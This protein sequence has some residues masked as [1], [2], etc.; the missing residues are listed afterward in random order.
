MA[1]FAT[2]RAAGLMWRIRTKTTVGRLVVAGGILGEVAPNE[3]VH[4]DEAQGVA[5]K[6]LMVAAINVMR[7]SRRPF[8]LLPAPTLP[9]EARHPRPQT[10]HG[11]AKSKCGNGLCSTNAS[12]PTTPARNTRRTESGSSSSAT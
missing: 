12:D 8:P 6:R 10:I 3:L 2:T 7:R 9:A 11:V 5:T 4:L 1:F